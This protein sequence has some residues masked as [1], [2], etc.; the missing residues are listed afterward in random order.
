MPD[1]GASPHQSRDDALAWPMDIDSHS[2]LDDAGVVIERRVAVTIRTHVSKRA[3]FDDAAAVPD[4]NRGTRH[5][6][7]IASRIVGSAAIGQRGSI[8]LD[9]RTQLPE[10]P[11][12]ARTGSAY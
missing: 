11:M 3:A 7:S 5:S 4:D 12:T 6:R 9:D 8:A 1:S 2:T 10:V